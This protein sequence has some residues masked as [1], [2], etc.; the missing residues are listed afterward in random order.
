MADCPDNNE[1]LTGADPTQV[2][3]SSPFI[4]SKFDDKDSGEVGTTTGSYFDVNK[5]VVP[6]QN[7]MAINSVINKM[8]G[9]DFKWFRAVPQQRS[10]DVIFQ[11][12][13]LYNV[14]EC[15]LDIKAVIPEGRMPDSK[16]NYDLMGLEYEIPVEIHI[17][18]KYWE[19]I[20]GFG[21]GP[22]KKDIVYF[23]MANKLYEVESSYLFRGFM[24]QETTWKVNL[25]KYQPKA[26]RRERE[27]LQETIDQYTVSTEEI[28]GE[29]IDENI[30]KL[31]DD[32]Q[33]SPYNGTSEDLYKSFD[34]SLNTINNEINMYGTVVSES[35]YNLHD[36]SLSNA[37]TYNLS[38]LVTTTNNR[39]IT[40]WF[41][42]RTISADH[43]EYNIS[44]ITAT[45]SVDPS[46]CYSYDA[47]LY[48]VANYTI[49]IS[50]PSLLTEIQ[51]DDYITISRPGALNLYAKVVAVQ[52]TPSLQFH[53]LINSFVLQDITSIKSDWYNLSGY[54]LTVKN[55]I[56]ILDGIN[57]HGKHVLSANVFANQ[58]VAIN[59]GDSY[60]DEDAYVIRMTDKLED[61][62]WYGIVVNI[63]N[64]WKQYNVYIW[65]KHDTDS[66]AKLQNVYYETLRLT[67]EQIPVAE[68]SINKS[69][70]YLTNIRLFNETI[71]E[72]RQANELLSYFSQDG[73]KLI[74]SDN[75]DPRL[76]IPFIT[77]QR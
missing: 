49:K 28:F 39:A 53:C 75:A 30:E 5:M 63:G 6:T 69:P 24:E 71:E 13:T 41:M 62:K 20:A 25:G 11:E 3:P 14:E 32:T 47:S 66:A 33:F 8:F 35:Y 77:K 27:A 7:Y 50:T 67:P 58:Y 51:T 9:Y 48:A 31:V 34:V 44:S 22:Q 70:A 1:D 46:L 12:Y 60:P 36:A 19:S 15:P 21:S 18:K 23:P 74:F 55:P 68:Y 40:A 61:D 65:E 57:S 64:I 2:T 73:D 10:K 56:S 38:D 16:Y 4:N 43:K 59:Y 45:S 37:I 17:D 52:N 72:E 29:A 26:S 42:P 76:R 54:K